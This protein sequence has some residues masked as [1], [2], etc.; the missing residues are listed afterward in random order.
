LS[1]SIEIAWF[2]KGVSPLVSEIQL[3]CKRIESFCS[4]RIIQ[5]RP[6]SSEKKCKQWE[7]KTILEGKQN[8]CHIVAL[9]PAGPSIFSSE[10][11][12]HWLR[13]RQQDAIP[14]KFCIGGAQGFSQEF[15]SQADTALSLSPCTMAHEVAMVVLVEQIYRATTILTNHPYHK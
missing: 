8:N 7:Q 11:F 2:H 1:F 5:N 15:V 3:L 14:L 12:A 6:L 4:C 10:H 9:S 13:L